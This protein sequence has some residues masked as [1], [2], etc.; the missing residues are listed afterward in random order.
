MNWSD[1]SEFAAM[2]GYGLY[3]WGSFGVTAIVML[4]EMLSL[5]ARRKAL[6]R[7]HV[8]ESNNDT[9]AQRDERRAAPSRPAPLGGR[10]TYPSAGGRHDREGAA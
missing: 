5:R 9:A 10:L 3:V 1:F 7:D 8:A 2:G 4:G 6:A